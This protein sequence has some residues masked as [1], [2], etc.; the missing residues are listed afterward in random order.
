[1]C[2]LGLWV[3]LSGAQGPDWLPPSC[4]PGCCP[5]VERTL[6]S[7][8]VLREAH[9]RLL[10]EARPWRDDSGGGGM[11]DVLGQA[12][13]RAGVQVGLV[14]G[15]KARSL[16]LTTQL[17]ALQVAYA[18][19]G[20]DIAGAAPEHREH[21]QRPRTPQRPHIPQRPCTLGLQ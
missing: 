18:N 3:P 15:P 13:Q 7:E 17:P 8:A 20:Y 6:V 19:S 4:V 14:Y 1:M 16:T 9:E 12:W 11:G 2:P 21:P 5:Q 10:Q